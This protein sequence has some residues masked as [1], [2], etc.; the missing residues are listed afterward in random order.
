[1]KNIP[2]LFF[3]IIYSIFI[4]CASKNE[5]GKKRFKSLLPYS[6]KLIILDSIDVFEGYYK[7]RN[8]KQNPLRKNL[9]VFYSN[10]K[11]GNFLDYSED[12]FDF[13]PEKAEM[14]FFGIKNDQHFLK[15]KTQYP[16]GY[17][18]VE[19]EII[20]LDKDSLVIYRKESATGGGFTS[21]YYKNNKT[22]SKNSIK[23]DW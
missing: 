13:N 11:V 9:I 14:G 6:K 19:D 20:Y 10:G 23:P 15:F 22:T 8:E 12:N 1:M 3:V 2:L 4:S 21:K 7:L 16:S 5:Y 17:K 18:V